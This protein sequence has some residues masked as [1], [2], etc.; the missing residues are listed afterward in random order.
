LSY[1]YNYSLHTDIFP[2]HLKTAVVKPLC[3]K[4][5]KFNFSNFRPILLLP[6]FTKILEKV[7]YSRLSRHLQTNNILAPEKY[8]F[9]KGMSTEDAAFRLTDSVLKSLNQKLY[10]GGIF[11]DLSKAFD[12]VNHEILLTK[13][14]FYGI[15]GITIDWFRSYLTN[16]EEMVE[17]KSP[18]STNNLVSDW[19]ILKHGVPKGPF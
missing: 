12:C 4:G 15:Q 2:D 6:S 18:N 14:H 7:I 11:C 9:R 3:K 10:V 13:L 8:A 16:R 1:I 17:I 5:D 19:R